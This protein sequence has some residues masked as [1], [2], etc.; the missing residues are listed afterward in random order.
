MLAMPV[1]NHTYRPTASAHCSLLTPGGEARLFGQG[2]RHGDGVI[3]FWG[4][5]LQQR[6]EHLAECGPNEWE[7]PVNFALLVL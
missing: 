7:I 6:V 3:V 5:L 2:A 1:R 4:T